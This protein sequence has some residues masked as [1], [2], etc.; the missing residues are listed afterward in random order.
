[1][2]KLGQIQEQK[3]LRVIVPHL[4]MTEMLKVEF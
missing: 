4:D 3:A 1:M 2:A